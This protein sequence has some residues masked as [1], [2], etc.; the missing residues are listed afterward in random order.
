MPVGSR[1]SQSPARVRAWPPVG[2]GGADAQRRAANTHHLLSSGPLR[3]NG[4]LL[5][6]C[7]GLLAHRKAQLAVGCLLE[8]RAATPGQ[9]P[10]RGATLGLVGFDPVA[11]AIA[12]LAAALG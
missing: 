12:P 1:S 7:M 6:Q 2:G 4:T 3:N 5:L 10:L 11:E 9:A 8:H